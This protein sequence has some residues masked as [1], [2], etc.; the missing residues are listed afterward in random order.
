MVDQPPLD[1]WNPPP[2]WAR[3]R[4]IDLHTAGE[5]LRVIT[6]GFPKVPGKTILERRAYLQKNFDHLRKQLM[7]EPRGHEGMYGCLITPPVS[8][9]A[10][11]GVIFMHNQ[12]YSTMCGHGIIAV[13]K[14]AAES[15]LVKRRDPETQFTIDTP[16]GTVTSWV[17]WTG[18]SVDSVRFQNVPSFV[19]CLDETIE[20]SGLG[21]VRYDIAFGGAFYAFVDAE[22]L[23]LRCEPSEAPE[24]I[25]AGMAIKQAVGSSR[26]LH[27]PTERDMEFLYGTIFVQP[28]TKRGVHSKNVCVFA[29]GQIDRS[30]TGTGVSARLAILFERGELRREGALII[31]SI[32][33]STFSGKVVGQVDCGGVPAV[34]P[35]IDGSAFVTAKNVFCIDPDDPWREGFLLV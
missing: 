29:D 31:E 23:G 17:H 34:I 8:P 5:P 27:H 22:R 33:G 9:D 26:P 24:I 20:V 32:I 25:K 10:A 7:R 11:F 21:Q 1:S 28:S 2:T 15:G 4:T 3:I 30:P 35:E 19:T 12:G 13:S 6:G 18:Q 14:I 16:A